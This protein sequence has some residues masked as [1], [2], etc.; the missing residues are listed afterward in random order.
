M[1]KGL[2]VVALIC[3]PG[4]TTRDTSWGPFDDAFGPQLLFVGLSAAPSVPSSAVQGART[5]RS[6]QEFAGSIPQSEMAH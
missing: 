6:P 1:D 4:S 5:G 2:P 3:R